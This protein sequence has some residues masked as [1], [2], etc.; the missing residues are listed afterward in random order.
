M[1]TFSS[2]SQK[3]AIQE[4]FREQQK[5][6]PLAASSARERI[7]KLKR[8]KSALLNH[9]EALEQ[10]LWADFRKPATEVKM[11]ELYPVLAE[12]RYVS[13]NLKRWMSPQQVPTPLPLLGSRSYIQY[14]PKGVVLIIAPWNFPVNLTLGP[15]VSALA[16]GNS[17]ILKPSEH[18]PHTSAAMKRIIEEA[19]E[20][21][22]VA[23]IE[24]GVETSQALL[25]LP[26]NHIFF[27]G[28]PEIGKIVM[29]AAAKHLASVTLELG[30]KSPTIVDE[31][32]D[33]DTAAARIA[34]GKFINNGQIC[35]S[36]DYL[37]VHE[38]RQDEFVAK[39]G[40]KLRDYY[41]EDARQSEDY[42]RIINPRHFQRLKGYLDDAA[43]RGAEVLIGGQT[44][45][46][47]DYIAPT[48]IAQVPLDA[49]LM[50]EEIF[51]PIL[52][53]YPYRDLQEPL[54]LINAREKPLALYIYSKSR[55]N[56]AAILNQTRAGGTCINHSV[57]H[58]S[59][60]H[61]PFGGDNNSGIGKSHGWFGFE[62]FS[63]ARAV[64]R[65]ALPWSAGDL[66]TAPYTKWK[67]RLAGFMVK[68][69]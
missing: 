44:A 68:W 46:E 24:G 27:T 64:Y 66:L 65:Q 4:L 61:L 42:A 22:E 13:R 48:V 21:H 18:T 12:I 14:Q 5:K 41:G 25:E 28:A 59:N 69:L 40:Q 3:A 63:N 52:P 8:L 30:G 57:M 10:A 32:A 9:G 17:V 38:S 29:A 1:T 62:A 7:G 6:R 36:P 45:A 55:Q 53:I 35:I 54:A 37:F 15:L 56:I 2:A 11:T 31:T 16:A 20:P 23:L 43:E 49:K 51:G 34:W 39:L 47:E 33:I 58:Y 19:F 50:T 26:F 67:Q 60:H